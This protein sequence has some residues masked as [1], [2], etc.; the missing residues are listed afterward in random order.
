M[1]KGNP[2]LFTKEKDAILQDMM[3][4]GVEKE[5]SWGHYV[6]GDDI[7]GHNKQVIIDYIGY[8]GTLDFK[9]ATT[10]KSRVC[11]RSSLVSKENT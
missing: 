1:Q 7:P 5:I 3:M 4:E 10:E 9:K 8:L 6:T 2:E 11:Q